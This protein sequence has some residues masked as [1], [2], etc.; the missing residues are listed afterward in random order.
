[1]SQEFSW[2]TS[3]LIN[4]LVDNLQENKNIL[5]IAE[6]TSIGYTFTII[7]LFIKALGALYYI[8]KFH[9]FT[10]PLAGLFSAGWLR[11]FGLAW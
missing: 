4:H 6:K 8:R 9:T 5:F 10:V 1:L 11:F 7:W 2:S 3:F